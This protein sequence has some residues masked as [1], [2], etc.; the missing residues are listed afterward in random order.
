MNLPQKHI[1]QVD[2]RSIYHTQEGLLE[3]LIELSGL[4]IYEVKG[5]NNESEGFV[6]EL[7]E[8]TNFLEAE[9]AGQKLEEEVVDAMGSFLGDD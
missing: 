6:I 2:E 1:H 9:I 4:N 5:Y 8:D 3:A 7:P